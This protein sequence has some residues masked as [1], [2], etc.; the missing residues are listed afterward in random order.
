M[1]YFILAFH[2]NESHVIEPVIAVQSLR[3]ETQIEKLEKKIYHHLS[4]SFGTSVTLIRGM[5]N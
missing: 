1:E 4:N 2:D 5:G 3:W